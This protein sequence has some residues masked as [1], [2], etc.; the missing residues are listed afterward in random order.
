M[1]NQEAISRA[2]DAVRDLEVA[3]RAE[4]CLCET[5]VTSRSG[6]LLEWTKVNQVWRIV[7]TF[8]GRR[9]VLLQHPAEARLDAYQSL[10]DLGAAARERTRQV[11]EASGILDEE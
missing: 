4:R 8:C 10:P 11:I 6:K 5:Q 3:L 2:T 1:N 7:Y 9:S